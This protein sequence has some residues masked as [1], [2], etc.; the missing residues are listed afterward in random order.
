M[1]SAY[2]GSLAKTQDRNEEMEKQAKLC[3]RAFEKF[4]KCR[5]QASQNS[6]KRTKNLPLQVYLY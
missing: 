4:K 2:V 6:Q 1:L 5:S 3:D